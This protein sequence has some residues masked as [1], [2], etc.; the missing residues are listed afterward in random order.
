MRRLVVLCFTLLAACSSID[1]SR[2]PP[3][4]WPR[5]EPKVIHY[6]SA[7]VQKICGGGI[8]FHVI[9]CVF[10]EF[11]LRECRIYISSNESWVIDHELAHCAGYDHAWESTVA[12]FWEGWKRTQ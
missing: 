9:A 10:F 2:A 8:L 11:N 3:A 5:L 7:E 6:S 4:D 1:Y 12:D